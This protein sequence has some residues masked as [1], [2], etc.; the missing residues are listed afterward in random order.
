M[1][2]EHIG[3]EL[4]FTV[5]Y[6]PDEYHCKFTIVEI[7]AL[8]VLDGQMKADPEA[9]H[10]TRKGASN[11]MD[12]V[13][14][15]NE[16]EPWVTGHVKWDGCSNIDFGRGGYMHLCGGDHITKLADTLKAV[17]NRCGE[18]MNATGHNTL[19]GEFPAK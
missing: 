15:V 3:G 11:N 6:E 10:Y 1:I 7:I 12:T 9:R 4:G 5:L 2:V 16:G 17:Y 19:E 14:D 13:K 8:E 18:L